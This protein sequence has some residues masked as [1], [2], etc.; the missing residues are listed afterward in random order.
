[1]ITKI[2]KNLSITIRSSIQTSCWIHDCKRHGAYLNRYNTT[3]CYYKYQ[4]HFEN[5][6]SERAISYEHALFSLWEIIF[7]LPMKCVSVRSTW[8]MKIIVFGLSKSQDALH[9]NL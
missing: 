5:S 3:H 7:Y 8:T 4:N 6:G 9:H 2:G 1:M